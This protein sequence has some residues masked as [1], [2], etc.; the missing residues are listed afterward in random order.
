MVRVA[1]EPILKPTVECP[2]TWTPEDLRRGKIQAILA[3]HAY[4]PNLFLL[5]ITYTWHFTCRAYLHLR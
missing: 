5:H 4:K 1:P 3:D 2:V